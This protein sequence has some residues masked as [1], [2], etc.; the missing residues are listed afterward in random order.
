MNFN[1]LLFIT[2][3][4]IVLSSCHSAPEKD[5][6]ETATEHHQIVLTKAQFD[7]N[8]MAIGG[9]TMQ[10]FEAMITCNGLVSASPDHKSHVSSLLPGTITAVHVTPGQAV[11]KG[12]VLCRMTS[13]EFIQLQN[14]YAEAAA[15]LKQLKADYERKQVLRKET[16]G[17]EK[18]FMAIESQYLSAKANHEALKLQLQ[19]LHLSVEPIE[20]G[21]FYTSYPLIAPI[22]GS[23]S[24]QNAEL[25]QYVD[26][27][28]PLFE[29]VNP[30]QIQ[31]AVFEKDL[32]RLK[33]GQIIRFYT[34]YQA[35]KTYRAKLGSIGTAVQPESKTITC[36]AT[37][38][39]P[40]CQLPYRSF[41]QGRV[42]I[43]EKESAALPKTAITE[44]EDGSYVYV[45]E[46][47]DEQAYYLSIQKVLT[48]AATDQYVE[49]V[50]NEPM[51][52]VLI[53]GTYHL[54]AE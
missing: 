21:E 17:S 23:V 45:V 10:S 1:T 39:A 25:G 26:P 7:A 51:D 4:F 8:Q 54:V 49:I 22:S 14:R 24:M 9:T 12:A 52:Q 6:P 30:D 35:D 15:Q 42:I 2:S 48:G 27:N 40:S 16:I 33:P 3:L 11:K 32:D 41:V 44:T 38:E 53:R 20:Q 34:P 28:T 29:I 13:T 43:E 37:I 31:L 47:S 36:L 19:M 18:E 50:S 46:K 5:D